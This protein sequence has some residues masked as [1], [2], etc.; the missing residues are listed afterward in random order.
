MVWVVSDEA[1]RKLLGGEFC[2]V[3]E[4]YKEDETLTVK[5]LFNYQFE[6]GSYNGF[7]LFMKNHLTPII[8]RIAFID[9]TSLISRLLRKYINEK[10]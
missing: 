1:M 2:Q 10:N 9:D 8:K 4:A 6:Y 7:R 3:V 5:K